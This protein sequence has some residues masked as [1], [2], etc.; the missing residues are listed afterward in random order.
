ME[1]CVEVIV[2]GTVIE[3]RIM[4]AIKLP[5]LFHDPDLFQW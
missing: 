5:W 4:Y 1:K 2:I 3:K